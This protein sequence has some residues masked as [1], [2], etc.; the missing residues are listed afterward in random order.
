MKNQQTAFIEGKTHH[1]AMHT[2]LIHPPCQELDVQ[3]NE[4]LK[5]HQNKCPF[6]KGHLLNPDLETLLQTFKD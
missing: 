1:F 2:E 4:R 6:Q 5:I 3:V